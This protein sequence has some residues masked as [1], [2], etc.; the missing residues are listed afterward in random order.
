M[1]T[2]ETESVNNENKTSKPPTIFI[3]EQINYNFCQK[4]KELTDTSGFDCKSS[5]KTLKL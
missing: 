3:Q 4:I 2:V 5:T 1:D